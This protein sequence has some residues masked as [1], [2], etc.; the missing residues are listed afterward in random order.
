MSDV[1]EEGFSFERQ[2]KPH[3]WAQLSFNSNDI[4][5]VLTVVMVT[6]LVFTCHYRQNDE[7]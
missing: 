5:V 3:V 1:V 7:L 4:T 6:L 2:S